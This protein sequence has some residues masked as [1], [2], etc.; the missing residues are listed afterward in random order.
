VKINQQKLKF[1]DSVDSHI[2][3]G[4]LAKATYMMPWDEN[5]LDMFHTHCL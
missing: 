4:A 5:A 3:V 1:T 2:H